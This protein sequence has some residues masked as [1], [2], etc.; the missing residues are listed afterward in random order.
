MREAVIVEA[1]RTPVG[2]RNGM[3]SGIRS[4]VLAGMVLK[5]LVRRAG[6]D[7]S[8][9]DDVIMGCVTQVKEQG[10]HIGRSATL[11]AGFPDH[12]PA[13]QIER[14]C[15]SSQQA[16]HFA[17]QAI[18]SGDMD[19][20]I[21][22]GI[23][24]MSRVP[25]NSNIIEAEQYPEELIARY[26]I[27]TQFVSAEMIADKWNFSRR[28]LDEYALQSHLKAAKAQD[29]GRFVK[30][31]MPVPVVSP[32]GSTVL[33]KEDEVIRRDTRLEK[34]AGLKSLKE[35]GKITAGNAS[36]ISDGSAALLVMSRE[37]AQEF[38]L[39]PRFRVMA[40]SVTGSDP[41]LMLLGPIPVTAKVLAKS[42]L[43]INDIDVFEVNEAFASV[44]M[45]WLVETGVDPAK[46]NPNGGAIALGHPLGCTGARLMTSMMHELER[47]GG[48][49]GMQV[50]CEG[51][52]TAN[53]TIIERL[54]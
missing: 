40:R 27:P 28:Q 19:V 9:V 29:A 1:V 53:A 30:E 12:V 5:E 51:G 48:R 8:H 33:F 44:V 46:L 54:D 17:A 14:Q 32:D 49:Y 15:G 25:M 38:G 11:I 52:G 24:N 23:E 10:K 36:A 37:K 22:A 42:G 50:M 45:A 47:T 34:L 26:D 35:N 41:I 13:I 6:I 43:S 7:P 16:V 4:E 2:R 39:M 31:I 20:V 3:L 18:I 21:A